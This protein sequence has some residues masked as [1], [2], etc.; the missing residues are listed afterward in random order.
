MCPTVV[1]AA[2]DDNSSLEITLEGANCVCV[3]VQDY[4]A[5]ESSLLISIHHGFMICP[6]LLKRNCSSSATGHIKVIGLKID[7]SFSEL[8]GDRSKSQRPQKKTGLKLLAQPTTYKL[9]K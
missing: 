4:H 9:S 1:S 5:T 7:P 6:H 8:N 2:G 3:R